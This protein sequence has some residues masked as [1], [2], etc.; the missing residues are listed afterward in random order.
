MPEYVLAY[1]H[2]RGPSPTGDVSFE[3]RFLRV[4]QPD[5]SAA[6]RWARDTVP[7]RFCLES[8]GRQY[9]ACGMALWRVAAPAHPLI[10]EREKQ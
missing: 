10:W 7:V 6:I 5:D 9:L 1:Q 8:G 2:P 3:K 4:M